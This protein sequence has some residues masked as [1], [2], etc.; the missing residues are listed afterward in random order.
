MKAARPL[1]AAIVGIDGSGKSSTFNGALDALAHTLRV[2]GVGD[3]FWSGGPGEPLRERTDIPG[4][5]IARTFGRAAKATSLQGLYKNLK[6]LELTERAHIA[7]QMAEHDAPDVILT[8]GQPLINSAAW[9]VSRFYREELLEDEELYR[10]ML[11][12]AGEQRIGLRDLPRFLRRSWQLTAFN[13]LRLG[14]LDF[15]DLIFLLDISPATA[16][17]R[18]RARGKPLQA[19]ETEAFLGELGEAYERVCLLLQQRRGVQTTR[20][21][22]GELSPA[23]TVSRISS[24]VLDYLSATEGQKWKR[25]GQTLSA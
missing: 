9:A 11:Y 12:L 21:P 17:E 20:V 6:L 3:P 13:L 22:V 15:P 7:R 5:R 19:H 23:D 14:R 2:A 8:D 1:Q 24:A 10:V 25:P 16:M 18:V 4:S